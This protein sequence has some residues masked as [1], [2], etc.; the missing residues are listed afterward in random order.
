MEASTSTPPVSPPEQHPEQPQSE[1]PQRPDPWVD[2]FKVYLDLME[3]LK[4]EVA[5]DEGTEAI[6]KGLDDQAAAVRAGDV[7][8]EQHR[9]LAKQISDKFVGKS[10]QILLRVDAFFD[11]Q[12]ELCPGVDIA[13]MWRSREM[14]RHGIWE[15]IEQLY[16]I[17]N[18]CL[19]PS[20]APDFLRVVRKLKE[21]RRA[22][23]PNP[24]AAI[25][26][27]EEN[28]DEVV[29]DISQMLGF[30]DNPAMHR[31][32]TKMTKH[33][34]E[35]M[36]SCD[37]PMSMITSMFSGDMSGLAGLQEEME[38]E[39]AAGLESG[40]LNEE[41]MEQQAGQMME[42][43]GG[44][45]GIMQMAS[46]LGLDIPQD[47]GATLENA[48]PD[49]YPQRQQQQQQQLTPEQLAWM[50]QQQQQQQLTPKQQALAQQQ[51]QLA[52]MMKQKVQQS[53]RH[54]ASMMQNSNNNTH[55]GQ[56]RRARL[57]AQLQER[58]RH[59]QQSQQSQQSNPPRT[60]APPKKKKKK[61]K[62]KKP[63]NTVSANTQNEKT[64]TPTPTSNPI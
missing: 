30:G 60:S 48:M 26:L 16:V 64:A 28:I 5:R 8:D 53:P 1:Q 40:E 3:A 50:Q 27:E 49:P 17:G 15:W 54:F 51:Q 32:M 4:Q 61:K 56:A 44:M 58:R 18:V 14:Y 19:H 52:S 59:Q 21:V 39:M 7:H 2:F 12:L 22:Q 24:D 11:E 37:D 6:V 10:K 38:A 25:G 35:K 57:Q 42:R 55:D 63:S 45:G 41:E 20:K 31:M 9:E 43:F 47:G 13:R 33:M 46:G 36:Q 29:G 62:K 23:E 34:S